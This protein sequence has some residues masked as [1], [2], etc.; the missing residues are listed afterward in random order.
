MC[1]KGIISH[2]RK[3]QQYTLII[4]AA[5]ESEFPG[6]TI[7]KSIIPFIYYGFGPH[8]LI[9]KNIIWYKNIIATVYTL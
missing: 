8:Q 2:L 7:H 5:T 4:A 9:L 1:Q 3:K 6:K